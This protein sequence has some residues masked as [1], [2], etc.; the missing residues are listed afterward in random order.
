[1][2]LCLLGLRVRRRS[3]FRNLTDPGIYRDTTESTLSNEK[4]RPEDVRRTGPHL[5][6]AFR[7]WALSNDL[8]PDGPGRVR[9]FGQL[10]PSRRHAPDESVVRYVKSDQEQTTLNRTHVP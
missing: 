10:V 3:R 2:R 9:E 6:R 1:M 4:A 8:V 7:R 5:A